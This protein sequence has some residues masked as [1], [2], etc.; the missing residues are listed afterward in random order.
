V[1]VLWRLRGIILWTCE[2]RLN[3][4]SGPELLTFSL[5]AS[6]LQQTSPPID[7]YTPVN[8]P[9]ELVTPDQERRLD[10]PPRAE[11]VWILV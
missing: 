7:D 5:M 3:E 4:V 11:N 2:S 1:F 10:T 9:V 8:F 6:N